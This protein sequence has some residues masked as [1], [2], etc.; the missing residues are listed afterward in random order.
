MGWQTVSK[1]RWNRQ[2]GT[3]WGKCWASKVR[4]KED[5]IVS[6]NAKPV[7][8]P[9][10]LSYLLGSLIT[11]LWAALVLPLKPC[12]WQQSQVRLYVAHRTAAV[13]SNFC[14]RNCN[15]TSSTLESVNRSDRRRH[16]VSVMTANNR[17]LNLQHE[18]TRLSCLVAPCDLGW[19]CSLHRRRISRQP[20]HTKLVPAGIWKHTGRYYY[21]ILKDDRLPVLS[22]PVCILL[23]ACCHLRNEC[24]HLTVKPA[25]LFQLGSNLTVYCDYKE[26]QPRYR[27]FF[28]FWQPFIKMARVSKCGNFHPVPRCSW[29]WTTRSWHRVSYPVRCTTWSMCRIPN[30]CCFAYC[31]GILQIHA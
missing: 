31:E 13:E 11:T 3:C 18:S 26:C 29:C 1:L 25:Q 21:R 23:R 28:F 30:P 9:P 10:H 4:Q 15:T 24:C 22:Q 27:L 12:G 7:P 5:R 20:W 6:Q 2:N 8:F 14:D 19:R 17:K 16:W